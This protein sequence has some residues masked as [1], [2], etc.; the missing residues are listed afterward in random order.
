MDLTKITKLIMSTSAQ[1][2]RNTAYEHLHDLQLRDLF[3]DPG[4]TITVNSDESVDHVINVLSDNSIHSCPVMEDNKCIGVVDMF[5]IMTHLISVLPDENYKQEKSKFWETDIWQTTSRAVGLKTIRDIMNC[6]KDDIFVPLEYLSP[7]TLA[8]RLFAEH[9]IHRSPLF[10]EGKLNGTFSQTDVIT[11]L[12]E[13][14]RTNL[15]RKFEPLEQP[16]RDLGLGQS[17]ICTVEEDMLLIQVIRKMDEHGHSAAPIMSKDGIL[18]GNFSVGDLKGLCM[19]RMTNFGEVIHMP[20]REY[21]EK[22]S[23][24]SMN[25]DGLNKDC[26]LND[27]F[28]FFKKHK[29]HHVYLLDKD[30]PVG[31][32]SYTDI[33]KFIVDYE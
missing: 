11:Y 7:V 16:V 10:N 1:P 19:E 25:K 28:D 6:S 4:K 26:V 15:K 24:S 14:F 3:I 17:G 9:G 27:V 12:C 22:Y 29:Y 23:P 21:M 30:E 18:V 31:V 13:H 5:D 8:A 2:S 20:I 33:M 32:I